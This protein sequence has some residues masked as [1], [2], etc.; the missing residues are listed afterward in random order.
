MCNRARM[1]G[2]PETIHTRFGTSWAQDVVRPNRDPVELVP[3]AK[4]YVMRS[5]RDHRVLDVIGRDVLGQ[6]ACFSFRPSS[7]ISSACKCATI[8][9]PSTAAKS[10]PLEAA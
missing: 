6:A 10:K 4:V 5:G 1:D 2:D 7:S 9:S 3:K 8:V